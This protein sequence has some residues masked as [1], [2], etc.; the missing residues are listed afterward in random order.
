MDK[1]EQ[2]LDRVCHGIGGPR[3]L[4]LHLRQEL[5]EHLRDAIDQFVAS[6]MSPD[7]A[8]SKALEDFGLPDQLMRISN[9]HTASV[10]PAC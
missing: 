3:S 5:R 2:Y 7:E 6:G 8:L 1:L 4:R 9:P 10:W